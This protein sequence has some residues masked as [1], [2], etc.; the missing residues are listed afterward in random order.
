METL[1]NS[2]HFMMMV[3]GVE[4]LDG[5]LPRMELPQAL[6][7]AAIGMTCEAS[8]VLDAMNKK[9]RPWT[10]GE[11][12]VSEVVEETIDTLFFFLEIATLLGLDAKDIDF[13][14]R[15]KLAINCARKLSSCHPEDLRDTIIAALEFDVTDS[16]E[17]VLAAKL[18]YMQ[19]VTV[20]RGDLMYDPA[21]RFDFVRDPVS[22]TK[23]AF[24]VR[25]AS[26]MGRVRRLFA[27]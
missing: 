10:E 15:R 21:H 4:P 20:G 26:I 1:L 25:F 16:S 17:N 6:L 23:E 27:V 11:D 7:S 19:L 13:L 12:S 22:Q 18:L 2:Q 8:E 9:N 5:E 24:G 14:Y 3:L